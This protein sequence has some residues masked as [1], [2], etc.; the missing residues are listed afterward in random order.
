MANTTINEAGCN[1]VFIQ[2]RSHCLSKE[3]S[4]PPLKTSAMDVTWPPFPI[5]LR[6]SRRVLNC[7]P[8]SELAVFYP[9]LY[10]RV[11]RIDETG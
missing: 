7:W 8:R 2:S 6:R 5:C 11:R 9:C 3:K 1:R 10:I 4:T